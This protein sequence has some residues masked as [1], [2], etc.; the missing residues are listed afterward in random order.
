MN[1]REF[2]AALSAA[3]AA[4]LLTAPFSAAAE[5]RVYEVPP[6]GEARVIHTCDTHAQLMPCFFREP[7]VNL[8]VGEAFGRAPHVVGEAM[9]RA[10]GVA[11][12]SRLAHALSYVGFDAL[13]RRYGKM[14]GFAALA[15]LI[16]RLREE[17]PGGRGGS[18]HLD[19]G[20]LWQ[21]SWTALQTQGAD[22]V[23]AANLLG[24]D[25]MVGHWEFTYGADV[26]RART[27]A[28]RAEFL[29]QNV[30]VREEALFDGAAAF[31]EDSGRA[32]KPYTVREVGGRR[33][34]VVG[35][36]FP[37]VPVAHPRRFVPEWTFGIRQ[38]ELQALVTRVRAVE[39]PDA[40][41]LLSHN[42]ADL[43]VTLARDLQGVDFILGGHTHD[44]L[45]VPRVV[46]G[47]VVVNTGC[48]GKFVGCL[49]IAF[50]GGGG[51][52]DYRWTM[53]PVFAE[54]L[55]ADGAMRRLVAEVRAPFADE[56]GE[57]LCVTRGGLY[58]RGN[59]NGTMDQVI[60]DA[61]RAASEARVAFSPGFRWGTSVPA[62]G[63]VFL[64]DVYNA[65]AMTYAETYVREM[66]GAEIH[67][68]LEE[69]ADNLFHANPYYRQGG[70]MVRTGGLRWT[71]TPAAGFG[72]RVGDLRLLDGERV[73][74]ERRYR[75]AG[76]AAGGE[77]GEGEGGGGPPVWEVVAEYLRGAGEVD[78]R[79]EAL[80]KVVGGRG[81]PG[82]ADYSD[83]LLE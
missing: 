42:G 76:W 46:E 80:P 27:A 56:L 35:Q 59:F 41:I 25:A 9:L 14:G 77:G 45:F 8:G 7:N 62:G 32:F 2:A 64:E 52:R 75:V 37:F 79:L 11:P 50:A 6:F 16:G 83:G 33:I 47:T 12:G 28:A 65:T 30:F 61:L 70:D 29:G 40:V 23:A 78:V 55:P 4:P 18:L 13:A 73:A 58:R 38:E 57:E 5:A 44:N 60:V 17:A 51:V 31:D 39:K 43:D 68:V 24:I 19:S 22:M 71:L 82:I 34:A 15:A 69:V 72:A 36:A 66:T 1:R 10:Y 26:L 81:N 20:D 54:V 67:A 48:V 3:A 53:L 49:D 21:G 63:T 74:A